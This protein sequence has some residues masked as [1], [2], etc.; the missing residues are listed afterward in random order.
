MSKPSITFLG[1]SGF[2]LH[3]HDSTLLI[4]PQNKTAGNRKGDIIYCTH[5]HFDHVGGVNAF[6]EH[7]PHAILIGNTQVAQKFA[8]WNERVTTVNPGETLVQQPWTFEF[9][10]EPHG[11]LK[12]TLNLGIIIRINDFAFGHLGDAVRFSGFAQAKPD[13]LTVPI[14]G[15]FTASPK[16]AID[17]L[18]KFNDPLPIII[19]MHWLFRSPSRFCNRLKKEIPHATCIVPTKTSALPL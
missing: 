14:F 8:K 16:R 6:L 18:K 15:G 11:F 5:K 9:I 1:H 4:D 3:Y 7:N 19:P 2:L 12:G 13:V 17:E 10:Q